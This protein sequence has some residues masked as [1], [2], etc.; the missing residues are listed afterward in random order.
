[1]WEFF[2]RQS[3][4]TEERLIICQ[5][6]RFGLEINHSWKHLCRKIPKIEILSMD[7]EDFWFG[8]FILNFGLVIKFK[9][10]QL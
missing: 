4:G 3:T 8:I 1:M 7:W 2:V 5:N 10:G 9:I 6:Y